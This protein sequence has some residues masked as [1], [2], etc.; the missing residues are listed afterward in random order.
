MEESAEGT[1]S[2]RLLLAAG[3]VL[4]AIGQSLNFLVVA[5]LARKT[6]LTEIQF[7]LA[8]TVASLPLLFSAPF[9]GRR[10]DRVGRKPVFIAG[11]LGSGVG[12]ALLA[13][14]LE[15]GLRGVVSVGWMVVAIVLARGFYGATS[16]AIYPSAAAYMADI[17]SFQNRAKGMAFIGGANGI[18]SI[19]GPFLAGSLAFLGALVPMYA[20]AALCIVGAAAAVVLL[21]E[22]ASH[23]TRK[24]QPSE[25]RWTD[26]RLRP[27]LIIWAFFF[28]IFISLNLVTAFFIEDRLGIT[29][30]GAVIRTASLA[31]LCM[32]GV[33]TVV[34][35]V[36][37]Q[38]W[39][40]PP[41]T[42]LRMFGPFLFA[43]MVTLAFADSVLMLAA[44]FTLLGLAFAFATPGI[45]GSAS[46]AMAPHEQGAAAGYLSASNTLGAIIAPL[47]GTAVYQIDPSA[48]FLVGAAV[49]FVISFYALTIKVPEP[50]QRAA[51]AAV[52]KG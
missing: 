45:N 32:A 21:R 25:L 27:F 48:P 10:S 4:F 8:F 5:P 7:G 11:L 22:P 47:F 31:L 17:T 13:L 24:Q 3:V 35:G 6:G 18:G 12:T 26:P 30:K 19:L 15:A 29:D 36:L 52:P 49:F 2:D 44:G 20:A 33:I 38:I 39:R 46:L 41:R 9:W 40:I 34:Q 43:S 1:V 37:L 42:L 51:A 14:A 16:S 28:L 23:F 50:G